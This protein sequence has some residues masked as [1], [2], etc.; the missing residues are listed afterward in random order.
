MT[1]EVSVEADGEM[2]H[3]NDMQQYNPDAQLQFQLTSET[4]DINAVLT[5][6][7]CFKKSYYSLECILQENNSFN[8]YAK[9]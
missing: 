6:G 7:E 4:K 2:Q 3:L 9:Y 5:Y 8:I 1:M